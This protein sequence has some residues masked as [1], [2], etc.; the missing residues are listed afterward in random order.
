M[1]RTSIADYEREPAAGT[2]RSTVVTLEPSDNSRELPGMAP[3]RSGPGP[4]GA[5]NKQVR[6]CL[7]H[8]TLLVI[9][10]S[11]FRLEKA[12]A[13]KLRPGWGDGLSLLIPEVGAVLVLEAFLLGAVWAL[14]RG[15]KRALWWSLFSLLH[16]AAYLGGVVEHTLFL[17]TGIRLNLQLLEYAWNNL[18]MLGALLAFGVDGRLVSRLLVAVLFLLLGLLLQRRWQQ[19]PAVG[20]SDRKPW[21]PAAALGVSGLLLLSLPQS[22]K[23]RHSDLAS[24]TLGQLLARPGDPEEA[25]RHA[26]PFR[27]PPEEIYQR[28]R[29]QPGPAIGVEPG[30]RPNIVL[31]VLESTRADV[32][33]PYSQ[34]ESWPRTPHLASLAADSRVFETAYASVTHTS[35]ALV[36]ILCGMFPRLDMPI[37]E[38]LENNLPLTCLPH[39]LKQAGY[40]SAFL[41]TALGEFENRPGL[42]RNFG[43]EQAA[44]QETLSSQG[45]STTGYLGMDEMAMVEPARQWVSGGGQ[46]PYF[47]TLLTVTPHHP[48]QVPGSPQAGFGDLV[49]AYLAS[50]H[51][52]D[53]FVG[54]LVEM[55][56]TAGRLE[57]TVVIVVGDHGEA[58]GEHWRMQHDVVPYEEVVR[59]PLMIRAPAILGEARRVGGLRHHVDLLP[60]VLELIGYSWQGRLP[61]QSLLTGSGHDATYSSCWFTDTCLAMREKDLKFIFHFGLRPTE[62]FDLAVD[63]AERR[64]LASSLDPA[65]L[66]RAEG[67]MLG[68][69]LSIDA[70]W[71]QRPTEQGPR[72]WWNRQP[73]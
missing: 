26:E 58:F 51:H 49:E 6:A 55:L 73:P 64:N 41:Q 23:I 45:F 2:L 71:Q 8:G 53:L 16:T 60:T 37:H 21:V 27:R 70:F 3:A 19:S 9:F 25:A 24:S 4:E 66:R 46:E 48:Y 59:V 13:L 50:I 22:E 11:F 32:V 54:R 18:A 20:A 31:V 33:A 72:L 52:Q 47:L 67:R 69:K 30:P 28:P 14:H 62:V 63:P 10:L 39:L 36:S 34:P 12:L 15:W 44:F 61:G 7:V 17:Y 5:L 56:S 68:W 40:R 35:K 38:S 42:V 29:A 43:F 65:D 1:R 57:D